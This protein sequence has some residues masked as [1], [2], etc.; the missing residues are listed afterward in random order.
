MPTNLEEAQGV[1]TPGEWR[2][3]KPVGCAKPHYIH[4]SGT[5]TSAIA[6]LVANKP[7]A[8]ANAHRIVT[9]VNSHDRLISALRNALAIVRLQNGNLHDDI[10]LIIDEARAAIQLAEGR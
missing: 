5:A 2:I 10:N 9:A 8:W 4:I 6:K 3:E 1:H 7:E